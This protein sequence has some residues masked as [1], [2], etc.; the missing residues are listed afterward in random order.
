[1]GKAYTRLEQFPNA[2]TELEKAIELSPQKSN[3]H[4][5]IAPVYRKQG[6]AE[7]A[8]TEFDR[9]AALTGTH[10]TSETTRP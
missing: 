10:S 2:Q 9:C 5:M 4:C 1:L 6:L 3:L 8:K 7:K